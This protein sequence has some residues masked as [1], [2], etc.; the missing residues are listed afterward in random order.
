MTG[1]RFYQAML[2]YVFSMAFESTPLQPGQSWII[3]M[4]SRGLGDKRQFPHIHI[5]YMQTYNGEAGIG[6]VEITEGIND[7]RTCH[8]A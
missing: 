8:S 4:C 2:D 5:L 6:A 3:P 7:E 1:M